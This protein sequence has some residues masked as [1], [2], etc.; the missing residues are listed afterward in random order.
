ENRILKRDGLLRVDDKSCEVGSKRCRLVLESGSGLVT[1]PPEPI[2]ARMAL[3]MA[4]IDKY[5][6]N[7]KA[8]MDA[9]TTQQVE[10]QVNAA[11]G[12]IQNLAATTAKLANTEKPADVPQFA[13]PVGAAVNWVAGQYVEHVKV[14]G[15]RHATEAAAPAIHQAA[16]LFAETSSFVAD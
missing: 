2:V 3:V 8:L 14:R 12:S 16:N 5:A 7:L 13:T 6:A 4:Q 9:D 15:L 11:L 1:Y 10:T